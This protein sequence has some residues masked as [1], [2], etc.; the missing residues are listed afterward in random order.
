M[1]FVK[2]DP[3]GRRVQLKKAT[4][5]YKILNHHHTNDN[6][7]N[8]NNHPEM[9]DFYERVIESVENPHY[10]IQDTQVVTDEHGQEIEIPHEKREEYLRIFFDKQDRLCLVKTIVEFDETFENGDIVTT[11]KMNGKMK[12]VKG[13]RILYDATAK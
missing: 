4:W 8:G 1:M 7:E 10:I 11:H 5:E 6:G 3:R 2:N 13:G 9:A 12:G